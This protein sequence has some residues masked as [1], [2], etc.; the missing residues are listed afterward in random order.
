MIWDV[1]IPTD[2]GDPIV[3]RYDDNA[4]TITITT[5][6]SF[7]NYESGGVIEQRCTDVAATNWLPAGVVAPRRRRRAFRSRY[8][9]RSPAPDRRDGGK[10][11]ALR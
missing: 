9:L 3:Y 7:D 10:D 8:P 11:R 5:D 6:Y 4:T 1:L 2:E